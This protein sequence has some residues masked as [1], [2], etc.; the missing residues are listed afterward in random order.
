MPP[1]TTRSQDQHA[2]ASPYDSATAD[3]C[4]TSDPSRPGDAI[5]TAWDPASSYF[6]HLCSCL[7][8][9]HTPDRTTDGR[10]PPLLTKGATVAAE[11]LQSMGS[12]IHHLRD[13]VAPIYN[14]T[15]RFYFSKYGSCMDHTTLFHFINEPRV[16]QRRGVRR[17]FMGRP[18][19]RCWHQKHEQAPAPP[20]RSSP[21]LLPYICFVQ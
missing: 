16:L 1:R 17:C 7:P 2:G 13:V 19:R 20:Y 21:K 3:A 9:S 11:R 4:W 12:G 14:I 6:S 10:L 8:P 5:A 18:G 15:I